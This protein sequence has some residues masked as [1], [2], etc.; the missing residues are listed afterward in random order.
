VFSWSSTGDW[1]SEES[2]IY[3]DRHRDIPI[4]ARLVANTDSVFKKNFMKAT[5][6]HLTEIEFMTQGFHDPA[7][8]TKLAPWPLTNSLHRL[9]ITVQ[10]LDGTKS[11]AAFD[12]NVPVWPTPMTIRKRDGKWP[13]SK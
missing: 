6:A 5:V 4:A 11:S 3:G 7:G 2:N 10:A 8:K 9:N 13:W 12:L 1:P